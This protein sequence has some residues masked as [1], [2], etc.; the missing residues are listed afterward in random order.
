MNNRRLPHGYTNETWADGASVWKHYV[1]FDGER[2]M[3]R[4]L[5]A[6][7]A[8]GSVVPTPKVLSVDRRSRRVEFARVVGHAGQDLID[9]GHAGN[10][11]RAAGRT[12]AALHAF[13]DV[14]M[15]HGDYGPQN[16]LLDASGEAV[17]LV[18]DWEF[19]FSASDPLSDLA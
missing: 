11:M 7:E 6:I 14:Q 17:V 8:V 2:R 12:L 10:V 5:E 18:A 9:Q 19:S 1:G 4:E 3:L 16:L 13:T 15:T